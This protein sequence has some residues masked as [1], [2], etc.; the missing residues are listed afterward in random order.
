LMI[1]VS[2]EYLCEMVPGSPGR[3]P[4]RACGEGSQ[5][6]SPDRL[7]PHDA[8]T[9]RPPAR[10]RTVGSGLST[11]RGGGEFALV[12]SNVEGFAPQRFH[13]QRCLPVFS[14]AS[15]P[16]TKIPARHC[17]DTSAVRRGA[18]IRASEIAAAWF[19][20]PLF[21]RAFRHRQQCPFRQSPARPVARVA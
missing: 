2:C 21:Q 14:S 20:V 6:H 1:I 18:D 9:Y 13:A 8:G 17:K 12:A 15:G 7:P 19:A 10:A 16:P 3:L 4:Q 11:R 5:S